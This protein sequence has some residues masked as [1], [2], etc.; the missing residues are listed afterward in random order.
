[1]FVHGEECLLN[2]MFVFYIVSLLFCWHYNFFI[3]KPNFLKKILNVLLSADY[4]LNGMKYWEQL[5]LRKSGVGLGDS[6]VEAFTQCSECKTK[7][8][9]FTMFYFPYD[10]LQVSNLAPLMANFIVMEKCR[11]Q[12]ILSLNKK[13]WAYWLNF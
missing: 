11:N 9:G 3:I 5:N 12:L 13:E 2:C 10:R 4:T 7:F 6:L 1:M 8:V